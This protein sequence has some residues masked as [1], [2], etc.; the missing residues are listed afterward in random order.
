MS[1]AVFAGFLHEL[2][3]KLER[4]SGRLK[5]RLALAVDQAVVVATPVKSGRA[6]SNWRVN[7][8]SP[9]KGVIDSLGVGEG[10][11]GPALAA[12]ASAIE[13]APDGADFPIH[14]TNNL[15]Y[16]IPLNDGHSA[17]APA[18]FI[19][20]SIAQSLDAV[21]DEEVFRG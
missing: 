19:Q 10:A 18:G 6:R 20:R 1:P 4:S 12:A 9:A 15:S 14:L 13:G 21:K 17:Q 8:G 2:T 11:T 7:I 3:I 16:I 5:R